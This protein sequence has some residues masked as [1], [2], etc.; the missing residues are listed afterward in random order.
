ML[1]S[2][3]VNE[4]IEEP[5]SELINKLTIIHDSPIDKLIISSSDK[6][7]EWIAYK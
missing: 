2:K 7:G 5:N 3:L 1:M 6:H 4:L